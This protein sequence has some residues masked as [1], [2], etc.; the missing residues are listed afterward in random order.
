MEVLVLIAASLMSL[1]SPAGFGVDQVADRA[2]RAQFKSVEHLAV[3]V[4][5]VS[6][7]QVL[8]GKADRIRIAGRGLFPVQDLRLDVLEIETDLINVNRRGVMQRRGKLQ[9]E[10]PLQA[11]IRLVIKEIDIVQAVKSPIVLQRLQKIAAG[12]GRGSLSKAS[13][14]I[15]PQ[16]E[17]LDSRRIR[18]QADLQ[19]ADSL[20]KTTFQIETGVEV[21]G[22]GKRLVLVDPKVAINGQFLPDALVQS[23]AN[24]LTERYDLSQILPAKMVAKILKFQLDSTQLE[25]ALLIQVQS[26]TTF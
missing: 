25:L 24:G 6:A 19:D 13:A 2:I 21:G 18:V 16:V 22:E 14:V 20:S 17:F 15:N 3:R 5:M 10:S 26:G 9:L 11:G 7:Q 23:I 4:D 1:V 12:L 8:Q